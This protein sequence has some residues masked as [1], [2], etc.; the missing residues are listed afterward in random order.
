[1][2]YEQ[3]YQKIYSTVSYMVKDHYLTE[4]IVQETFIKAI[5]KLDSIFDEQK[6]GAW[7]KTIAK[8]TAIDFLRK[9][10]KIHHEILNESLLQEEN[11]SEKSVEEEVEWDLLK[12]EI[13]QEIKTLRKEQRQIIHLKVN[14]GWKEKEIANF[15]NMNTG[16]VKIN[17]FRARQQLRYKFQ[18]QVITA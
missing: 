10:K 7:L 1:M 9:E 14:K 16:T 3:H 2:L 15:L 4:D 12:N 11:T 5:E 8:R 13:E 6:I 17:M 18:Q